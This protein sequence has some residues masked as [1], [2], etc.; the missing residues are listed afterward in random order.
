MASLMQRC[1][2]VVSGQPPMEHG[3][4]VQTERRVRSRPMQVDR[5][6]SVDDVVEH[7]IAGVRRSDL[8]ALLSDGTTPRGAPS[9]HR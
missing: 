2:L 6:K 5:R 9:R 4:H 1:N 3:K 7:V 8:R